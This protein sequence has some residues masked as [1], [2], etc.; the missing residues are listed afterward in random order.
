MTDVNLSVKLIEY[1]IKDDYDKAII[2][3]GDTDL[4][5]AITTIRENFSNKKVGISLTPGRHNNT[6]INASDF[7]EEMKKSYLDRCL[8]S[9]PFVFADGTTLSNPY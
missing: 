3:S 1:A 2:V 6:L 4:V 9:N 5:P 8:L 7:V